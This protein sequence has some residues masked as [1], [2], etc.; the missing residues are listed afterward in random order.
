MP[1]G[2]GPRDRGTPDREWSGPGE[3]RERTDA[4]AGHAPRYGSAARERVDN[5]RIVAAEALCRLDESRTAMLTDVLPRAGLDDLD[6]RARRFA[7]EIAYGV[8]RRRLTLDCVIRAF[9]RDRLSDLE[10]D[11]LQALRIGVYQLLFL[12]GVPPFAAI[13][14]SVALVGRR[15]PGVKAMVNAVLRSV[16]RESKRV[17]IGFDLGTASPRKRLQ[18]GDE[19][20]VFFSKPV[21]ADPEESLS[22]HLGQV[23]S[24]PPFLVERWLR[25]HDRAVVE[26]VLA[27]GNRKP[28]VSVRLNR[29][30]TDRE[31]LQRRLESEGVLAHPGML[32]ESL[33]VDASPTELVRTSAFGEGLFYVQDEAAMKVAPALEPKAGERILDLCAAPGGK[34]THLAERTAGLAQVVAVDASAE[35][36]QRVTENCERLGIRNVTTV[37]FRP[38]AATRDEPVPEALIEPFDAALLD[39]PCSNTGVLARRPE[40]RWRVNEDAIRSLAERGRALLSAAVRLVK[41]GGRILYST[42]SLEPE[43]NAEA[44]D[45]ALVANPPLRRTRQEETLPSTT[46]PDGGFF[47]RLEVG[48]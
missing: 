45:R 22:L 5:P 6:G 31:G 44:I 30:R 37:V 8:V 9:L 29:M 1:G 36:L 24:H 11:C 34:A 19:R 28:R 40:A 17:D 43:E 12:D 48:R 15:H 13:S 4:D 32:D 33:I 25:R 26:D 7:L 27:A 20:V 14:E 42:C 46:G 35:R 38:D 47:A 41:P 23:H 2:A 18:V 16:D 39:V 21:F 3:S 10:P